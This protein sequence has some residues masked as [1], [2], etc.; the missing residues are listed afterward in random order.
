[1]SD[2]VRLIGLQDYNTR[3]VLAGTVLL[4]LCSGAV[5]TLLLLRKRALVGDVASHAALPGVGFAYLVMER[6]WPGEGRWFPGLLIGAAAAAAL[7][8]V[9][10]QRIRQI[11]RIHEDASLAITLSLFF[12]L[13][14]V[15]LTMIQGLPSGQSAGLSEFVFGKAAVL[16]ASDVRLIAL[17]AGAVML[18]CLLLRKE[19]GLLCFDAEY[20]AAGG[21]PVLGLDL[22][23]TALVIAVTVLGMQSVGL[24]LVVA[25]LVIPPAAARFWTHRLSTMQWVAA[26]CGGISAGLGVMISATAPRLAAGAVIVLV[27]AAVFAVSLLLGTRSGLVWQAWTARRVR[28]QV[29]QDDLMRACY[30]VLEP[31]LTAEAS[32]DTL[33]QL[34][35][36]R[37]RLQQARAWSSRRL[38]TLMQRAV[39]EQRLRYAADGTCRLTTQGRRDAIHAVRRHRLW[40]RYLIDQLATSP[41]NVDQQA[42][43]A[44]HW[45]PPETIEELE[46]LWHEIP[47]KQQVPANPH[48]PL[49]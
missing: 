2:W 18:V 6:W 41:R 38:Q 16:T 13:G 30:E 47:A 17:A 11:R 20:A 43:A 37:E 46:V 36:T 22:L 7:G 40:E 26:A 14:V 34:P 3:V 28:R 5:G 10:S 33:C 15:L 44:E 29:G 23:L 39:N 31:E 19:F 35:L 48:S 25:L 42:D 12:G 32:L 45:L 49:E 21:W 9:C 27:A 4:G 24:L 1:M 8:L